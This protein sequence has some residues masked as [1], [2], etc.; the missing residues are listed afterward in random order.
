MTA[1]TEDD[2]KSF[3]YNSQLVY[4]EEYVDEFIKVLYNDYNVQRYSIFSSQTNIYIYIAQTNG[5]FEIIH[6]DSGYWEFVL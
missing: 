6:N 4:I 3:Y 5:Y 2:L 1:F